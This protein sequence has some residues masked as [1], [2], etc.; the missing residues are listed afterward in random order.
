MKI[1]FWSKAGLQTLESYGG[2]SDPK[3]LRKAVVVYPAIHNVPDEITRIDR[4]RSRNVRILFSGDFFRKGGAHVV[5]AFERAQKRY[6]SIKLKLCCD[7]KRD[8]NTT[9][10]RLRA[11]YLERIRG[12]PEIDLGRVSREEMIGRILPESD[13]YLLPTYAEAFG[14]AILEALAFGI[15]VISTTYF[16]IPEMIED[17]VNGFLID[18]RRFDCDRLFKGYWVNTIPDDFHSYMSEQLY[19]RLCSLLDS[20]ELRQK[21]G[22]AGL[23]F[24]RTRFSTEVRKTNMRA[25]Y[26]MS[27]S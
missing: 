27:L 21:L 12:N 6:P 15:P 25:I 11:K 18:T 19:D 24:A 7:E 16:A 1:V 8:F 3:L 26:E 2:A 20:S 14:Y 23:E 13:I 9:D 10:M 4:A 22:R 17:G 5:D